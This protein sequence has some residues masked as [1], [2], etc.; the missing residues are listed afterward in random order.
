MALIKCPECSKEISD[1]TKS[2]P[3]CGY[4]F[5]KRMNDKTFKLFFAII[6]VIVIV[7]VIIIANRLIQYYSI[8]SDIR[9]CAVS[10]IKAVD[11]YN[12]SKASFEDTKAKLKQI[13]NRASSLESKYGATGL[14]V[15][16]SRI[17][18]EISFGSIMFSTKDITDTRNEVAKIIG[19]LK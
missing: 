12:S 2:C 8:K 6:F 16:E 4:R 7:A 10:Y 14:S 5:K 9:Q 19:Y 15:D 17:C 1:T 18:Y 3:N 11:D 13:D